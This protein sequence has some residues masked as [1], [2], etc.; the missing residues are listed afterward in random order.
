[1]SDYSDLLK[2]VQQLEQ[3]V[4]ALKP[5][6]LLTVPEVATELRVANSTAWA[7]VKS[8]EVPSIVVGDSSRRVERIALDAYIITR[9]AGGS[10]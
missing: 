10:S 4:A 7:L 5:T 6:R 8:G 3:D 9:R 1:M 2:R